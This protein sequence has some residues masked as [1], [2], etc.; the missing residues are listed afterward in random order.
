MGEIADSYIERMQ[1]GKSP[2]GYVKHR[3][4][5]CTMSEELIRWIDLEV[6]M[7]GKFPAEQPIKVKIARVEVGENIKDYKTCVFQPIS[8]YGPGDLPLDVTF[9]HAKEKDGTTP[10]VFTEAAVDTEIECVVGVAD[11][12]N[13]KYGIK[14][15]KFTFAFP[16]KGGKGGGGGWSGGSKWVPPTPEEAYKKDMSIFISYAKDMYVAGK[17]EK[18]QIVSMAIELLEQVEVSVKVKFPKDD[19][20]I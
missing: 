13:D 16:W 8:V 1:D 11:E 18:D 3:K 15:K 12:P 10:T 2:V 5:A 6:K 9:K 14:G 20:P 17:I 4:A 19:T 7:D